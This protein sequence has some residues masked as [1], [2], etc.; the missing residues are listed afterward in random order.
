MK[1]SSFWQAIIYKNQSSRVQLL[2]LNYFNPQYVQRIF[3]TDYKK[4]N[5]FRVKGKNY[6]ENGKACK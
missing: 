5:D 6:S 4:I 3:L 2:Q 1:T